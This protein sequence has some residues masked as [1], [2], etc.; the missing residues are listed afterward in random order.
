MARRQEAVRQVWPHEVQDVWPSVAPKIKALLRK[1]PD[2]F[3]VEDVYWFLKDNKASLFLMGD[4]FMVLEVAVEPFRGKRTLCVWLLY[5]L[6]AEENQDQI[7]S[8]LDALARKAQ[9]CRIH[10][11]SP[12]KGWI[13]KAHGFKQKLITWEREIE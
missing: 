13:K 6:R 4:G 5:W 1:C 7:Y 12:R 10:F 11:K 3:T 9:C 2:D 8:E